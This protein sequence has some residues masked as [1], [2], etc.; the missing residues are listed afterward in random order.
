MLV[1]AVV[2]VMVARSLDAFLKVIRESLDIVATDQ[3]QF[4]MPKP[5]MSGQ[6]VINRKL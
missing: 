4:L 5:V 6:N 3:T 1:V 2:S